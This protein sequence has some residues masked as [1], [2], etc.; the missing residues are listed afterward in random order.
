M[1]S[2]DQFQAALGSNF[3]AID[4]LDKHSE[5]KYLIVNYER[6]E[7]TIGETTGPKSA[8]GILS[9]AFY[10]AKTKGVKRD[11][12]Y[13]AN[14]EAVRIVFLK[15]ETRT[16]DIFPL[17]D[18]A[19]FRHPTGH[20]AP[21]GIEGHLYLMTHIETNISMMAFRQVDAAAPAPA[22]FR[23]F[24]KHHMEGRNKSKTAADVLVKTCA[25]FKDTH[26]TIL[27]LDGLV[28]SEGTHGTIRD[29]NYHQA[30]K[31]LTA[32]A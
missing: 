12:L 6:G 1:F 26:F 7:Y 17:L 20:S 29:H 24:V 13:K 23:I 8:L 10:E 27:K 15:P 9:R 19:K 32:S 31:A 14:R 21:R 4:D 16:G 30:L 18:G 3:I 5:A 11:L 25:D 28:D 22:A 2:I